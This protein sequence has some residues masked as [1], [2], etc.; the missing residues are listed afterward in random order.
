M[1][2]VV[3]WRRATELESGPEPGSD[4]GL[5]ARI[6]AEIERE[7]PITFAR[8]MELA[9]YAP[10]GGYYTASQ[11]RPGRTGDFLTAPEAHPI[12]G[13]AL[14]RQAEELWE[15]LDRPDPFVI[16]E[17]GAGAGSL[18][19][20]LL[21]GL[22][23]TKSALLDAIRY[24]PVEI[25]PRRVAELERRVTEAGHAASLDVEGRLRP[26]VTG[27]VI[28]N[29][30]LDALPVHRVRGT[31]GGLQELYVGRNGGELGDV[32]GPPSSPALAD[33]LAAEGI[34]LRPG[35]EAEICLAIDGWIAAAA[36]DLG[37]G[38]LLILDYGYP[39]AELYDPVKRP[40]GTL[41]G[42]WRHRVIDD[43][44]R[45][46]GRQDLGA[47]VDLTAV[48]RAAARAGLTTVGLT[49]QAELLAGLG[50]GELLAAL[51]GRAEI[52]AAAYLEARAALIRMIDPTAMGRFRVMAFGRGLPE[53]ANLR[54]FAFRLAR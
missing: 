43:P 26:P 25:E 38:L 46:I 8:F 39:A 16:R 30:V 10:G 48:E 7:G 54:G 5:R 17:H 45:N 37:R 29:E 32:A 3:G 22:R 53:P 33:R 21:D 41:L 19:V 52:T 4:P 27:L 13:W 11:A 47:H 20:G 12:F 24:Q 35:Q 51:R 9:L 1:N 50:A 31:A 6:E 40:R 44:F 18:I 28:A 36:A 23:E 14:A 49:T 15:L 2:D 42:Y 34:A